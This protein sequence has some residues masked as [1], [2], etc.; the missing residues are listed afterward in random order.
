MPLGGKID[1]GGKL[2]AG[3]NGNRSVQ[4]VEMNGGRES[5]DRLLKLEGIY[6]GKVET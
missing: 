3:V 2:W 6:R 5:V 1:F 4:W